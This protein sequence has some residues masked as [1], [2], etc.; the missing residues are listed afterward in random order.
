[1]QKPYTCIWSNRSAREMADY[2]VSVFK[3]SK[4]LTTSYYGE[5]GDKRQD[6]DGNV[7]D[8][9]KAGTELAIQF[10]LMGQKFM[11]LN[12][13]IDFPQTPSMSLVAPCDDQAE[14]DA[15]W[16]RLIKDGG[17]PQQCGWLSDK[18][19]VNWQVCHA[20]MDKMFASG[21]QKKI[22]AA[23]MEVMKM[24]QLDIAQIEKAF[25]EA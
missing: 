8:Q 1:M 24:V 13:G 14:L 3:N 19:G 12:G 6:T 10:E 20:S 25:K 11:V 9:P 5:W 23:M 7:L 21:N 22:D 18:F 2:Y 16:D 17:S 15:L 4:I